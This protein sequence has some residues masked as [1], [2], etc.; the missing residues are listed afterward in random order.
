M[1]RTS[2][3]SRLTLVALT[4]AS[5]SCQDD[6]IGGGDKKATY[7]E[8][9]IAFS[10]DG[11]KTRADVKHTIVA[12]TNVVDLPTEEGVPA[13]SLVETVTSLDDAYCD[14]V[15]GTRG[16]PVYTENFAAVYGGFYGTAYVVKG[17][18][19]SGSGSQSGGA[20][21]AYVAADQ[22]LTK[23][24]FAKDD[25]GNYTHD[26]TDDGKRWPMDH[27]L[28]F[29]LE[30][31][32]TDDP[33]SNLLYHQDGS[34]SFSYTSPTTPTKQEDILFTSKVLKMETKDTDNRLLFYHP[35][36]GVK[37]K[38]GMV[39]DDNSGVKV[40]I[41]NIA[42][43]GLVK[44]GKCVLTPNYTNA[45]TTA[46]D[47]PSNKDGEAKTKS[48]ACASWTPDTDA[49]T[50]FFYSPDG[51]VVMGKDAAY[52]FPESFFDKTEGAYGTTADYNLNDKEYSNTFFFIP[53]TVAASN[54]TNG[55]NVIITYKVDFPDGTTLANQT[56][57][58][59]LNTTWKAGELH[60]YTLA[61][62]HVHVSI[63]D[64]V[65]GNEKTGLTTPNTGNAPEYQRIVLSANWVYS[66]KLYDEGDVIIEPYDLTTEEARGRFTNF[67]GTNWI[68]GADG[69]FYY[70]YP[71][72]PGK[73][74]NVPLFTKFTAPDPTITGTHLEMSISVQAV[75]FT[76]SGTTD[77]DKKAIFVSYWSDPNIKGTTNK[78]SDWLSTEADPAP[79]AA[80]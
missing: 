78:V 17:T 48:A 63:T 50:A 45:N 16:T 13:L 6:I 5:T 35:L 74:P 14:A 66:D 36:T 24:W 39:S 26:Y 7:P 8:S 41:T 31:N 80:Q 53:Q 67:P 51:T 43:N 37:F 38:L 60:T 42:I 9:V 79:T 15:S 69:F 10:T 59:A 18:T 58:I 29:F 49:R 77:A 19:S 28:F 20:G 21:P 52:E 64:E 76:A 4:L 65:D 23:A 54:G 62:R 73:A 46:G 44:S 71:I 11:N 27:Q 1:K 57:T 32:R 72:E 55:K 56:T 25:N 30:T 33:V 3:F 22:F 34:F 40:T 61:F 68:E 75:K 70:K 47:N 12:P 2:Y